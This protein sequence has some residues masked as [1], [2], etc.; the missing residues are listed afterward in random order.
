ML[1]FF[2][3]ETSRERQKPNGDIIVKISQERETTSYVEALMTVYSLVDTS[4][5]SPLCMLPIYIH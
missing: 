1:Y 5:K 2:Q 4:V 3:A